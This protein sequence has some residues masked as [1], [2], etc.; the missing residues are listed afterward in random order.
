MSSPLAPSIS[1]PRNSSV[2]SDILLE[3]VQLGQHIRLNIGI[4]YTKKKNFIGPI[5]FYEY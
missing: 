3:S 4:F 2:V 1:V 5:D